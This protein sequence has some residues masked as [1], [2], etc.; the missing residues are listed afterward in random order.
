MKYDIYCDESRQDLLVNKAS[1]NENNRYV[2][3]GGIMLESKHRN[4]IKNEIRK[5]KEKYKVYG[6]LK[7]GNVSNNKLEFYLELV[8]LFFQFRSEM[9]FRVSCH[10]CSED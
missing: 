6:E 2:C 5:L 10:R 3:I 4:H 7:W 1:V 9:E 8:D